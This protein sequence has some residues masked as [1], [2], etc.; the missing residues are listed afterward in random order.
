MFRIEAIADELR[1]VVA[2][3]DPA[4]FAGRDAAR[5]TK[6][7]AEGERLFTAAKVGFAK[8][9]VETNGWVDTSHV[10]SAEQWLADASGCSEFQARDALKTVE[11]LQEL[12]ATAE[13]L[14]GGGLSLAQVS[15]VSKAAEVDRDAEHRLL[16]RAD[17]ETAEHTWPKHGDFDTWSLAK[18]AVLMRDPLGRLTR[19]RFFC[20]LTGGILLPLLSFL[21][22]VPAVLASVALALCLLGELMERCTFFCAVVPPRMPGAV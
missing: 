5:P 8:R 7:C 16:R 18:S 11:R 17:E 12:P 9:A 20:G 15:L 4:T 6:V 19:V 10:S 1:E 22:T 13:K 14:R 21:P 2:G 3:L